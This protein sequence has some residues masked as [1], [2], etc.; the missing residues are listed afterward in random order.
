MADRLA[1]LANPNS[2][3]YANI[4]NLLARAM[5]DADA[6]NN[7]RRKVMLPFKVPQESVAEYERIFGWKIVIENH[8]L[9]S[10]FSPHVTGLTYCMA[11][12]NMMSLGSDGEEVIAIDADLPLIV[13]KGASYVKVV[14]SHLSNRLSAGYVLE[15]AQLA[16]LM[17]S[18]NQ[19]VKLAASSMVSELREGGG[20]RVFDDVTSSE[21]RGDV[22]LLDHS[23]TSMSLIQAV[24]CASAWHAS[25]VRGVCF[26]QPEMLTEREGALSAFPGQF[27]V[28]DERDLITYV[29]AESPETSFSHCWSALRSFF[30]NHECVY[31]GKTWL[32]EKHLG[33]NG[34]FHYVANRS[35]EP[36]GFPSELGANY[37]SSDLTEWIELE[38]PTRGGVLDGSD[39]VYWRREK[40]RLLKSLYEKTMAVMLTV[41][42]KRLTREEVMSV[43]RAY[44]NTSVVGGD[45]VKRPVRVYAGDLARAAV[46]ILAQ[47]VCRRAAA[48]AECS[49][50]LT[51]L[52]RRYNVA[53]EGMLALFWEV[54]CTGMA[55]AQ[56]IS[57]AGAFVSGAG[58][59]TQLVDGTVN[60]SV[61]A[62]DVPLTVTITQ[63]VGGGVVRDC[64]K[65]CPGFPGAK[66]SFVMDL[67]AR[68]RKFADVGASMFS[69]GFD[70]EEVVSDGGTDGG[71]KVPSGSRGD[72]SLRGAAGAS[73]VMQQESY[74]RATV[75][76][77]DG[78]SGKL[79]SK[80]VAEQDAAMYVNVPRR[81]ETYESVMEVPDVVVPTIF[82]D[83][84]AM[85]DDYDDGFPGVS[86]HDPEIV[87]H[88]ASTEDTSIVREM[89]M[90]VNDSKREIATPKHVRRAKG[91]AGA[92]GVLPRTQMGVLAAVGK[93][94]SDVP[95][96]REF[97]DFSMTPKQ[98]VDKIQE[99][100]YVADWRDKLAGHLQSGLW[101]PNQEDL[102]V[103]VG[104]VDT[105]KAEAMLKTF[106]C[107]SDVDLHRW[108]LMVK[109]KSKPPVDPGAHEKVPLPQ[110]IMYNES[111]EYNAMYSSQL[112]RFQSVVESLM[113][114]NIQFNDRRSPADHEIWFNSLE[115]VRRTAKT[116]YSY[117]GDSY[118]FDRSQELTAFSVELEFYRRHGL[119]EHT[120]ELWKQTM[121][122][123]TAVSL[124]HGVLMHIVL[125]GL[126]GIFKTLFRN[127]LVTL[128]SVVDATRI[129]PETLV[130][131]D[132]KGD[133]Y[134]LETVVP[135]DVARAVE[136]LAW[137]Y[138]FSAKLWGCDYLYFCSKYWVQVDGWWYWVTDPERKYESLCAAVAVDSKGDTT[139]A[140]KWTSLKDDLRHYNNGLVV[141]ELA[142]AVQAANPRRTRPPLALI[143]GLARF[144]EDRDAFFAFYGPAE[145]VGL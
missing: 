53:G 136:V 138:N 93:R 113:R 109:S 132:I 110:T 83:P 10:A 65:F 80:L 115:P 95:M 120:L 92:A 61:L 14:R 5:A 29:P 46:P 41:D 142:R 114:P 28:D 64:G 75:E 49:H 62:R 27:Y 3:Y 43:M 99:V 119:D 44:N 4:N 85:Q 106:F 17:H 52:R 38:Y 100:C 130:S 68:A 34:I 24:A 2:S 9:R 54:C 111:K 144:A 77:R 122:V 18:G 118:N 82:S 23:R 78:L 74:E 72:G 20:T 141:E 91:R 21:I 48:S 108:I 145:V 101:Q 139:L 50:V 137:R 45:T 76:E 60:M 66:P 7:S 37:Y 129:T 121:G 102:N 104:K 143:G 71:V 33:S 32:V 26:F 55:F 116:L 56:E 39:P 73:A 19:A 131:L 126:S 35:D 15:D 12:R 51:E 59:L 13:A 30:V 112:A 22:V 6:A 140:E 89:F 88:V 96:N 81:V 133:D 98:A 57:L 70:A 36:W 58:D 103:Y 90:S 63:V 125:Q 124:M 47:V 11:L 97:V 94:N 42:P 87:P 105:Q 84:A 117:Q 69:G 79:Y 1:A 134:T 123:K 31:D 135:I 8:G 40:V 86:M 128:A 16:R 107:A 25:A 127:G 67:L